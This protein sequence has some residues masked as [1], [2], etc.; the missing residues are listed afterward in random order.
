[1]D[2]TVIFSVNPAWMSKS[3]DVSAEK[4]ANENREVTIFATNKPVCADAYFSETG[5]LGSKI[6]T[7]SFSVCSVL[8]N[9]KAKAE[10]K[11]TPK[12]EVKQHTVNK[13]TKGLTLGFEGSGMWSIK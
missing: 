7:K 6:K 8:K 9:Q 1:M 5:T 10:A 4:K 2:D 13:M 12:A 11:E 3:P